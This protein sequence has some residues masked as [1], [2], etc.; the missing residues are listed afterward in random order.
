MSTLKTHNLQSPDAGSVNIAMTQNAGMV[1][2]GIS[3][4]TGNIDANGDLDVDGHTNLD[5]VSIAGVTTFTGR[6][7][8]S[9]RIHM[10][11]GNPIRLLNDA[12][13][14][15]CE[16]DC[17]GGAG[18][19]LTSYNQTMFTCENGGNTKFYTDSGTLRLEI[20]HAGDV[21]VNTGTLRIPDAL[22]HSGDTDTKIR[23]P[24]ADTITAET[25]GSERLR[26]DSNGDINLGNN[27]TNQ[28]GYKLNIQ[29]TAILYAQTASSGGTEL[30]LN[31]DH[32]NT[33]ATFGTVSTSH[34]AFVT[35]NTERLR[36]KS[37]GNISIGSVHGAKKVHISTTGNQKILIDP[38][39]NN[40]SGGSSNGEADA[41]NVVDS[42]LI[43][44]SFGSNAA[45]QTNAGHK[46]GIKFQGYNGNDFTQNTSKIAAVYAV[47]EDEAGG[48]NRNVGLTFHTSPY[49]TA[50]REVMRINTN[51]I[52]TKP[53]QYVF[54]VS[55]S[56]TSKS[57]NWS[58]IT[59][60]AP[61]SAQCTNV[62]DGTNWSNS[63]QQFT[64]PVAG[65]YHFFVGGW[66]N[67]NSN[68]SRYAYTFKHTNGNNYQF[69]SG[70]DYCSGDSPMAG[71][72][73]TI[74]LSANEWVE[75][76]GYS[77]I[78]ATWGGGH[79]FYWGGY[80]LG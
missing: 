14:A 71:W 10:L 19:R 65:V 20:T 61:V 18:F 48:Y 23:F 12:N 59:G 2:T 40:N 46:W 35:A 22:Q 47:S 53:Y 39:Y 75:L 58:K 70:G 28:Y 26:I 74:K 4:F 38:N 21:I 36:I 25:G 56:G 44:T 5:N 1:V 77:A 60:L 55:T 49:N 9:S 73:R 13:S 34:L 41:N 7:D 50:H 37:D 80:L 57:A 51:G 64:A 79:H 33:I 17:Y 32:G 66:A 24:A 16:I 72:S 6:S 15:S 52:V 63:T 76:W 27:P 43:R 54:T 8:H 67:P 68:G 31:L 30:K 45:S 42:V 78:S 29:D 3:T 69:I 62:S 11:A